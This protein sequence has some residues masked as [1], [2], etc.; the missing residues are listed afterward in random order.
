[1][2]FETMDTPN[3]TAI[4]RQAVTISRSMSACE[5]VEHLANHGCLDITDNLDPTSSS[6][7]PVANGGFGDVYHVKLRDGSPVAVKTTRLQVDP[8]E[9]GAKH[10]KH[11]SRELHIWAKCKHRNVLGLLGVVVFRDRLGMVSPWMDHGSLPSYL[12]REPDTDRLDICVQVAEGLTYLH[13]CG[14]VH[15]DLKG[16]NILVS[17]D[18]IPM[19]ADFG[20]A[21]LRD[22]S[23]LFTVT[24]A[25]LAITPRWT[26]PELL[27][28]LVAHCT[29]EA[30]VYA[31]GMTILETITGNVPYGNK[32]DRAIIC[33]VIL[34]EVPERPNP[35]TLLG[36][37]EGDVLWVLLLGCWS[38]EPKDRPSAVTVT[39]ALR[40]IHQGQTCPLPSPVFIGRGEPLAWIKKCILGGS[41]ERRIFVLDGLGGSG[42][43]QVALRFVKKHKHLFK[44]VI[45]IDASSSNAIE[46]D[47]KSIALRNN[48]GE[49][50]SD[51][52]AWMAQKLEQPWLIIYNDADDPTSDLRRY[53]PNC[54]HGRILITTRNHGLANLAQP[55]DLCYR[56]SNMPL[57]EARCLLWRAANLPGDTEADT[58]ATL[59]QELGYLASAI[60]QAGS[61]IQIHQST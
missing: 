24:T 12:S 23:L 27:Q 60:V 13:R 54:S 40:K 47:L 5:I 17:T 58:T 10:L 35:T 49:T 39:G 3:K 45:Y 14:I 6:Q 50:P 16:A 31:L 53:F 37:K 57:H 44:H 26:A 1:M 48:A 55:A 11:A 4:Q 46:T 25:S 56:V 22:Q 43:T 9:K 59:V 61:Y 28:G 52:L 29:M 38:Y 8:A 33:S 20:N 2:G 21:I 19:L 32:N 18:G 7:Y 15:G 36:R 41:G 51:A 34:G 30:D 42:K